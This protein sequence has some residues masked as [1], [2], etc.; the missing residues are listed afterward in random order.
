MTRRIINIISTI[1]IA[2]AIL[3]ILSAIGESDYCTE[4]NIYLPLSITIIKLIKGF[5]I[6]GFGCLVKIF[7]ESGK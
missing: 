2:V 5:T 1:L 6:G 7:V 4:A 3:I